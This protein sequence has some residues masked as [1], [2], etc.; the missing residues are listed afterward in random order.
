MKK[1]TCIFDILYKYKDKIKDNDY[2]L[3]NNKIKELYDLAKNIS[4]P[5]PSCNCGDDELCYDGLEALRNCVNY[6]A[7][8]EEIPTIELLYCDVPIEL[9]IE[10]NFDNQDYAT[11]LLNMMHIT[12]LFGKL[13]GQKSLYILVISFMD[14]MMKNMFILRENELIKSIALSLLEINEEDVNFIVFLSQYNFDV[15][16]WKFAINNI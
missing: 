16:I 14:Y 2:L 3:L 8:V 6:P 5:Q 11:I 9:A 10:P 15:N 12:E 4:I 13:E 7:F 1:F